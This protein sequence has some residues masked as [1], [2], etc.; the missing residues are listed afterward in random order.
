MNKDYVPNQPATMSF[1]FGLIGIF[2]C[3]IPIFPVLAILFGLRGIRGV[4]NGVYSPGTQP[5]AICGA[6]FGIVEILAFFFM[7]WVGVQ[8]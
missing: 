6:A 2:T 8:S 4:D 1:I 7:L 5:M 3:V